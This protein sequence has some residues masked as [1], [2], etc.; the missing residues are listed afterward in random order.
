MWGPFV[1]FIHS[2]TNLLG[3]KLFWQYQPVISFH[4]LA[5]VFYTVYT[6][7]RERQPI[8]NSLA[9]ATVLVGLIALSNIFLFH[10][11]YIHV[12]LICALYLYL[13]VCALAKLDQE[14]GKDYASLALLSLIAFS[15][16]RIEAPLFA[17]AI[18]LVTSFRW[19]GWSYRTR[20]RLIIPYTVVLVAWYA[21]VY[22]LLPEH[23]DLLTKQLTIA[24]ISVFVGLGLFAVFSGLEAL[25]SIVNHTH[26]LF[27]VGLLLVAIVFTALKP[28][29]MITSFRSMVRN[30]LVA[31]DWGL[32][33]YVIA[34]LAMEVYMICRHSVER[35]WIF[36]VLISYALLVYDLTY[37]SGAY[38]IGPSDSGNR[39]LLQA[40][41][42]V[43]L[44]LSTGVPQVLKTFQ[45]C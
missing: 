24:F 12:N 7:A 8:L 34:F 25:R 5:V 23:P 3:Q 13:S 9:A 44:Y 19:Q 43:M 42:L 29:Q 17:V 37:L 33:W 14:S 39:L 26:I 36:M 2:L 38:R 10:F 16:T 32:T 4:L 41:P 27:V 1:P 21:R 6:I 28:E 15:L 22:F 31:G 45:K 18:L 30:A 11:F 40:V 35:R 20:L